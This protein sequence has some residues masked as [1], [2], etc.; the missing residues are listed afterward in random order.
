V[1]HFSSKTGSKVF[2]KWIYIDILLGSIRFMAF[3]I[4]TFA[5][6]LLKIDPVGCPIACTFKMLSVYKGLQKNRC[7]TKLMK[8]SGKLNTA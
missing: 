5:L 4:S 2:L 3:S 7:I 8:P 6:G 1:W